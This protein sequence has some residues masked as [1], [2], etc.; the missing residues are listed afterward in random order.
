MSACWIC[1]H[2]ARSRNHN[3]K[4]VSKP[5]PPY[6]GKDTYNF[7]RLRALFSPNR[8]DLAVAAMG[9]EYDMFHILNGRSGAV[10]AAGRPSRA[11]IAV[12]A[13]GNEY[14]KFPILNGRGYNGKAIQS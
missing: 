2:V 3:A 5:T 7:S 12:A 6:H 4:R 14:E 10:A 11:D 13:M 8:A 9:I 1:L